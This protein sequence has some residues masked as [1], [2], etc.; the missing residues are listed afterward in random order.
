MHR[1]EARRYLGGPAETVS[2]TTQV[3]GGGQIAV[4]LDGQQLVTPAR[5]EL[6]APTGTRNLEV[7]LAGPIDA[8]CVVR[9]ATVDNVPGNVDVDLLMRSASAPAPVHFYDFIV[10]PPAAANTVLAMRKPAAKRAAR[11]A[12]GRKRK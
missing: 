9:I 8:A 7:G 10:P 2:V 6:P 12:K 1:L 11:R 5:F 4:K 3:E